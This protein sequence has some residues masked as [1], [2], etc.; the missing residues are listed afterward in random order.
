MKKFK[1]T[2]IISTYNFETALELCLKSVLRQTVSPDEIVIADDG[3]RSETAAVVDA[4]R[5]QTTIPVIHVWQE[6]AGFRLAK[7]RNK[8]IAASTG[9]YII[10]IDGDVILSRHL[11]RD[12]IFCSQRGYF[13]SGSRTMVSQ[14]KTEE[15]FESGRVDISVWSS[16]VGHRLNG[17]RWSLL[18]PLMSGSKRDKILGCNM[19]F[20]RDDIVRVN[21][22]N[23]DIV[24]WGGEDY[25]LSYRFKNY[26]LSK[27][28]MKF[29]GIVHHLYHRENAR[30]NA[31]MNQ[32]IEERSK[33]SDAVRCVNGVD[34]YL[35]RGDSAL[36]ETSPKVVVSW[37]R[38]AVAA[39]GQHPA[40]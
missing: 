17:V 25:E 13:I 32:L 11:I 35:R 28:T 8:A 39:E 6:D 12:H 10:Q 7:I 20:W 3:S 2:L 33:N 34:K 24:G 36:E 14:A 23:E 26:G 1:I 29:L 21:G 37:L 31:K 30:D 19:S 38:P 5:R 18:T 27:R 4:F 9:D 22:Y 40:R 15:L 16:G